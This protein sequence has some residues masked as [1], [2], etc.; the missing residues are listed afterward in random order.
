[1]FGADQKRHRTVSFFVCGYL[2][3]TQEDFS[4]LPQF[5][6]V[7]KLTLI[8]GKEMYNDISVIQNHP[9]VAGVSLN[10]SL[11]FM[12]FIDIIVCGSCQRIEHA[13]AGAGT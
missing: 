6:K 9:A 7:V 1:M 12:I 4:I 11:L 3:Q 5:F 8:G 13:V 10:F 2:L